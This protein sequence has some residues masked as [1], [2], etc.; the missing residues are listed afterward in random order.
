MKKHTLGAIKAAA[1]CALALSM[2]LA[3]QANPVSWN[4]HASYT[5]GAGVVDAFDAM[6]G[7]VYDASLGAAGFGA[8]GVTLIDHVSGGSWLLNTL[9][10]CGGSNQDGPNGFT[11]A[12]SGVCNG[13]ALQVRGLP[14]TMTDA[15]GT[16]S[17]A[18]SDVLTQSVACSVDCRH[19]GNAN[20]G[21]AITTAVPEPTSM[22]LA[23]LALVGLGVA[24]RSR[25]A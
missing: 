23:G 5:D 20:A 3:A 25:K 9:T 7:F 14:A 2:P 4:L 1:I 18:E 21:S 17:I 11:F 22:V 6:G 8:I 12:T 16:I 13:P 24:R 10:N 19:V 15:G